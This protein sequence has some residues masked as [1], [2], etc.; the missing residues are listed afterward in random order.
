MNDRTDA[1]SEFA[2]QDWHAVPTAAIAAELRA[3]PV[4]GLGTVEAQ[5]R[6]AIYGPNELAQAT[7]T[8]ALTIF[9]HQFGSLVI[10]ILILAAAVSAAMGERIDAIAIV[11]I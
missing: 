6:L 11:A 8:S 7:A 3:D 4:C 10:W 2:R 5:H 9:G 1:V